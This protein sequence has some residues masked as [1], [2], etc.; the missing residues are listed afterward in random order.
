MELSH[1]LGLV[2]LL[3]IASLLWIFRRK[4]RIGQTTLVST[5]RWFTPVA[6]KQFPLWRWWLWPLLL[7]ACAWFA[8]ATWMWVQPHQEISL[9]HADVW[10]AGL[11]MPDRARQGIQAIQ[12]KNDLAAFVARH[13]GEIRLHTNLQLT[14]WGEETPLSNRVT[15]VREPLPTSTGITGAGF[16]G[17]RLWVQFHNYTGKPWVGQVVIAEV[18]GTK[19]WRYPRRLTEVGDLG[20]FDVP[21]EVKEAKVYL[22]GPKD[23]WSWDDSYLLKRPANAV[24]I[25]CDVKNQFLLAWARLMETPPGSAPSV[26]VTDRTDMAAWENIARNGGTVVWFANQ[27]CQPTLAKLGIQMRS[28]TPLGERGLRLAEQWQSL[29][30]LRLLSFVTWGDT[31]GWDE[32]YWSTD[33]GR[34]I[35]ASKAWRKGRVIVVMGPLSLPET[36]LPS[37]PLFIPWMAELVNGTQSDSCPVQLLNLPMQTPRIEGNT[38]YN[39]NRAYIQPVSG[40]VTAKAETD[41]G[42]VPVAWDIFG[43]VTLGVVATLTLFAWR[44][45]V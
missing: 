3:G 35:V 42:Q 40:E 16:V 8:V 43:W 13:P 26:L 30:G 28:A 31:M 29:G 14:A 12:S 32:I 45:M 7:A 15:L 11:N 44:R 6:P 19:T 36:E 37:V 27:Q 22:D 4:T 34:P 25:A 41:S 39:W 1:P 2:L 38:V 23:D 24:S 9:T 20:L 17:P 21:A 18:A 5:N 33:S 10:D